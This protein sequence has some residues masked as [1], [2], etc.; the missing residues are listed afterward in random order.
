MFFFLNLENPLG[1]TRP[2]ACLLLA[3]ERARRHEPRA[4]FFIRR[5]LGISISTLLVM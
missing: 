3:P 1:D 2:G 5:L 4:T